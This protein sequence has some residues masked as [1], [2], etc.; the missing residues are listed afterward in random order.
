MDTLT[1]TQNNATGS[2]NWNAIINSTRSATFP[3]KRIFSFFPKPVRRKKAGRN[4]PFNDIETVCTT[5]K[6][7]LDW[8]ATLPQTTNKPSFSSQ[9]SHEATAISPAQLVERWW[10]IA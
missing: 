4:N 8:H 10:L 2:P 6:N 7:D 9:I 5:L 1:K 3:S